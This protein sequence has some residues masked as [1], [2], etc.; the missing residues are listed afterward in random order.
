MDIAQD[1]ECQCEA[2]EQ[3]EVPVRYTGMY[4]SIATTATYTK[5]NLRSAEL[6]P[7]V[8]TWMASLHHNQ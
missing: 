7:N 2:E 5:Q 6:W 4:R 3:N 1:D 8:H